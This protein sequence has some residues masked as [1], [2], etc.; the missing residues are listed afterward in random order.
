MEARAGQEPLDLSP[1][2]LLQ[3]LT[4]MQVSRSGEGSEDRGLN[5]AHPWTRSF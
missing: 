3:A 1:G 4:I 5:H 2:F